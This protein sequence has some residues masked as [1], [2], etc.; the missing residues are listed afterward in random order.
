METIFMDT[1]NSKTNEAHKFVLNFSKRLDLKSS[2][3]HVAFQNVS[4][5]YTWKNIRKKNKNNKPK[6]IALTW[7]DDFELPDGSYSVSD[8]WDYIECIISIPPLHVYI[9]RINN[10]SVFKI[11]DS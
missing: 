6:I 1:E 4:I 8:I 11:R 5:Y 9:I 2:N 10:G 3:K 7:S